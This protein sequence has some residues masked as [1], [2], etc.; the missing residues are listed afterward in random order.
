MTDMHTAATQVW[1]FAEH[2]HTDLVRGINT[3]HD[4]ACGIGTMPK[5]ELSVHLIGVTHWLDGTLEP[6][7]A[8]EEAW[9]YPEIERRT[10][11]PW[12]T[13]AARFDHHQIRA[14]A[15]RLHADH[16]ILAGPE[17]AEH[18]VETRC[19]LF[20]LVALLRAH[21]EREERFLI[22]ILADGVGPGPVGVGLDTPRTD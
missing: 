17:G 21:I 18:Q 15:N 13:R 19:H 9:L 6:H 1:A 10:G 12:P 7:V 4:L 2:E 20:S 14:I 3:I 5:P 8:W 22:P 11:S 16:L